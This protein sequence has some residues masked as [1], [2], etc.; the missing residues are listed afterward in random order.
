MKVAPQPGVSSNTWRLHRSKVQH[1]VSGV[2]L[3]MH[4][5]AA[6]APDQPSNRPVI[7]LYSGGKKGLETGSVGR[8]VWQ[9]KYISCCKNY[10]QLV[11]WW[12][13]KPV[14]K[15]WILLV[16]HTVQ[17][18]EGELATSSHMRVL[19]GFQNYSAEP[20]NWNLRG[21]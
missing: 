9:Q 1:C 20:L 11:V 17:M 3:G 10:A 21:G 12:G 15:M 13:D 18:E 5:P 4:T 7:Q 6:A 8:A 14:N 19:W 2:L 16:A